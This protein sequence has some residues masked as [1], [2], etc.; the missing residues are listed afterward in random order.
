MNWVDGEGG[1][2]GLDHFVFTAGDAL[3]LKPFLE[4]S[5]DEGT[6]SVS[7]LDVNYRKETDQT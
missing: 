4:A 5:F 7:S 2:K 6:K 1:V 3:N